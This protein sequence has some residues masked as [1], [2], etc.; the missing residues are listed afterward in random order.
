MI[1]SCFLLY[2]WF[3]FGLYLGPRAKALGTEVPK[4]TH[5]QLST[6]IPVSANCSGTELIQ[7]HTGQA[8]AKVRLENV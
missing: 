7:H 3:H 2:A 8:N 4:D 6:D 5:G 1:F